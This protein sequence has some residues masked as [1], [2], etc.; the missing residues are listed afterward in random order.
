MKQ[1][2]YLDFIR[3]P[4][5]KAHGYQIAKTFEALGKY[6]PVKLIFPFRKNSIITSYREY[7]SLNENINIEYINIFDPFENT[8]FKGKALTLF[9]Y[10]WRL[11]IVAIFFFRFNRIKDSIVFYSRS[12]LTGILGYF[13]FQIFLEEHDPPEGIIKRFVYKFFLNGFKGIIAI[14]HGVRENLS[15]LTNISIELIPDSSDILTSLPD[16]KEIRSR[17]CIPEYDFVCGYTGSIS[18]AW[19]GVNTLLECASITPEC[20]FLIAGGK[21]EELENISKQIPKN[22]IYL[23]HIS[24]KDIIS[25]QASCD[26]LIIPN[27]P[28]NKNSE[29][30]TSPLKLFEYFSVKIPVI[31][32]DLESIRNIADK[33]VLYFKAGN[34]K[35]LSERIKDLME[36]RAYP[37]IEMAFK[38][39]LNN[40]WDKR[41]KKIINYIKGRECV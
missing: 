1:I 28:G 3:F 35:S 32:S 36:R 24:R 19:K 13:G 41:A 18:K 25:L 5:E 6:I 10:F 9:L 22:V 29:R 2:Y 26:A 40:T 8:L 16:R 14:S 7:Y 30:F 11:L 20:T 27:N 38:I 17:F 37:D 21:K 15:S 33:Y 4:T 12:F 34:A 31:A 23:E 39:A